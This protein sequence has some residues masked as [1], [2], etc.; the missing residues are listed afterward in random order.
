MSSFDLRMNAR[1]DA[2]LTWAYTENVLGNGTGVGLRIHA[3]QFRH[4]ALAWGAVT[5]IAASNVGE[6][7]APIAWLA[8]DSPRAMLLW[9]HAPGAQGTQAGWSVYLP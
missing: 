8:P 6:H 7:F 1:G 4:A 9:S 3:R 2:L 5:Q